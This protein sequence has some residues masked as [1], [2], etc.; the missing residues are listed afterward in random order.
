MS[1]LR[2][3]LLA[4][5]LCAG[6]M[7]AFAASGYA[8]LGQYSHDNTDPNST[9]CAT[10][11]W[12]TWTG[13]TKYMDGSVNAPALGILELRYSSVCGTAWAKFTCDSTDPYDC[14]NTCVNVQRGTDGVWPTQY[15]CVTPWKSMDKGTFIYS[16]QLNDAGSLYSRACLATW[17]RQDWGSAPGNGWCTGWY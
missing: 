11:D 12:R 17:T 7:G 2:K 10:N 3:S 9:G 16:Y 14:T 8:Y 15:Q 13:Y 6:L 5:L 1:R 4:V